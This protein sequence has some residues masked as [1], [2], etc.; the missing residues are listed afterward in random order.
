MEQD[1]YQTDVDL[2]EKISHELL[3]RLNRI[4]YIL[5]NFDSDKNIG[6]SNMLEGIDLRDM[7]ETLGL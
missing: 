3:G 4:E 5:G 7:A 6:N 2:Y 1:L